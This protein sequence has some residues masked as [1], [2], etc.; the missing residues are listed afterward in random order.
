MQA[1]FAFLAGLLFSVGLIVSGMANP[2]KVLGFLDLAGRWD[3]SLA[4][5]MAGAIGVAVVAFAWAK[6]R[7]RSWLG[8]PI[9]WPAARTITVRLVAGSAVFGIGW[10]LAGFCP[11]PALVSIGLG[12]VKGIAFVVAML[13]GM[14]LFE[15]IERARKAR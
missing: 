10:G 15:W 2:R 6:R 13:V 5:V 1:G 9:Q 14:A 7:T 12:S 4:F 3:P 11:G 8:L